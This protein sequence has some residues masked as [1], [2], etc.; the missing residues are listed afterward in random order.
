MREEYKIIDGYENY[1]I[2][3]C[4]KVFN[5][6]RGKFLK[7]RKDRYGYL[8]VDLS[9]N[10]KAKTFLIHRIVA[11]AFIPNPDNLETVD[12]IGSK[13]D[14]RACNLRWL[15]R[16]NNVKRF[17]N[18]Q[19]T[20]EQREHYKT[21]HKETVKKAQETRKKAIIC[22]ETGKIYESTRQAE[23][24]LKIDNRRICQVLKGQLERINGFHFEYL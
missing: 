23:R 14:N 18:E 21:V 11:Q 2:S 10:G 1:M 20:E 15:T 9:K 16:S 4:G 19:M 3:N 8:L 17:Y 22:I 7:L 13:T 6:K 5:I 12:H 24:E